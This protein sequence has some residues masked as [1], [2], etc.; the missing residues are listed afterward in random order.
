[1]PED[2][3][4]LSV[5]EDPDKNRGR[6]DSAQCSGFATGSADAAG[7]KAAGREEMASTI[8]GRITASLST[9]T[10]DETKSV[11]AGGYSSGAGSKAEGIDIGIA[12][13]GFRCQEA[14]S[15]SRNGYSNDNKPTTPI[16]T[17]SSKS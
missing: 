1:M 9:A 5:A 10:R 2:D 3:A 12:F 13:A 7:I 6:Q 16:A 8:L 15:I 4:L 14:Q 11:I 17:H